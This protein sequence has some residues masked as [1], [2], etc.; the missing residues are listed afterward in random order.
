[1]LHPTPL[2][3][4]I[5]KPWSS[6]LRVEGPLLERDHFVLPEFVSLAADFYDVTYD[7]DL[8]VLTTWTAY[9]DGAPANRISVSQL[10]HVG[11]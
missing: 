4:L 10:T 9:I 7:A 11:A 1:M 6:H 2:Q 3:V 5:P 8:D